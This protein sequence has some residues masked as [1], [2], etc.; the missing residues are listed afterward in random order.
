MYPYY[1]RQDGWTNVL[2]LLQQSLYAEGMV[3]SMSSQMLYNPETKDLKGNSTMHNHLVPASYHRVTAS[4]SA[5]RIMSGDSDPYVQV[6]L[7]SCMNNAATQD[8]EV[9]KGLNI[10]LENADANWKPFVEQIIK[11]EDIAESTLAQAKET[12]QAMNMWNSNTKG[13][14]SY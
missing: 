8:K 10:M 9:R 2:S 1:Y 3:C 12:L 4:G 11:W 7:V 5:F 6:T 14:A 13:N